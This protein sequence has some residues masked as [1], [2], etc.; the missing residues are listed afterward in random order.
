MSIS[1]EEQ[2]R[3]AYLASAEKKA[4]ALFD[5][6]ERDLL[7]P[8]ITEKQLSDE[9]H[10]L[11]EQRHGIKTHWH[12]RVVRSG[13]NTLCPYSDNPAD[14]TIQED[15]IIFVD[16]GPVFEKW[17]AD[18]GRTYVFGDDPN[19][20]KIRDS[21]EPI[22]NK[23]KSKYEERPDMTGE[24]LYAIAQKEVESHDEN[25]VFGAEIAGHI[26][27]DFPHERIPKDKITLYITPGCNLSMDCTGKNGHKRHWILEIHIRDKKNQFQGFYE[28]L[29]TA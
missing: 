4:L 1:T 23:V 22:W 21:L 7:R 20:I 26:V 25:W 28:Q 2:A 8:G 24:E 18:F 17:E 13:P 9:I 29:L 15:D 11:G 14:R 19:K 10:Q 16:L 12:K 5:E 27:G 6:I 3:A